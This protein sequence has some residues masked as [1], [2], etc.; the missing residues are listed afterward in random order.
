MPDRNDTD[1]IKHLSQITALSEM[2]SRQ[3]VEEVLAY[4]SENIESFITRRHR[5]LQ[6]QG[7][8]NKKMFEIIQT[9][10]NSRLFPAEK[11]S[12]RKIRRV[13]YG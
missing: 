4:F 1:L 2:Q 8:S 5:E 6:L 13:I 3:I 12:E 11:I 7:L 9:E 10:L